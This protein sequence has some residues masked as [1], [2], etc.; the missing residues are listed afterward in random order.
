MT[1]NYLEAVPYFNTKIAETSRLNFNAVLDSDY[2]P[3]EIQDYFNEF[4]VYHQDFRGFT[5]STFDFSGFKAK[6]SYSLSSNKEFI[7]MKSNQEY[8][9]GNLILL[10]EKRQEKL[11][12][13]INF[14]GEW[15][16]GF[17]FEVGMGINHKFWSKESSIE[18]LL[19]DIVSVAWT[20]GDQF[21][22][23]GYARY[24]WT[25]ISLFKNSSDGVNLAFLAFLISSNKII[26]KG[27]G[28]ALLETTE[29]YLREM[30]ATE[31]Q[32]ESDNPDSSN[33]Y[34]HIGY[35]LFV[36]S[37]CLDRTLA[38]PFDT[39]ELDY[40]EKLNI[41]DD[42]HTYGNGFAVSRGKC[43]RPDLYPEVKWKLEVN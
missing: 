32:L 41:E 11:Q 36:E 13:F 33:F 9:D 22:P 12:R 19:P 5:V 35:P 29:I 1:Q 27:V 15:L 2:N 14:L 3:D 21:V 30:G 28:R 20:N 31:I 37:P 38:F 18:D 6:N 43:L 10:R 42:K 39:R 26:N 4:E 7:K 34:E 25:K 17:W 16:I 8:L 40:I 24:R 23:L